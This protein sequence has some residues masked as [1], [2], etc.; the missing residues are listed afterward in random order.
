MPWVA[1]DNNVAFAK[2]G[3]YKLTLVE[4]NLQQQQIAKILG[5][6]GLKFLNLLSKKLLDS[7]SAIAPLINSTF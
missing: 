7:I 3:K 5:E 4:F 6:Q 1:E 2:Q